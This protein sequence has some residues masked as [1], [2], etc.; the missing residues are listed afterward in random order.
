MKSKGILYSF[1]W[2]V[3]RILKLSVHSCFVRFLFNCHVFFL[4][5]VLDKEKRNRKKCFLILTHLNQ[6]GLLQTLAVMS[7]ST[8]SKN[9]ACFFSVP[10]TPL[11]FVF[12]LLM[13]PPTNHSSSGIRV[14]TLLPNENNF[15]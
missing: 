14:R 9:P 11:T 8:I 5:S 2:S 13:Q 6:T 4:M 3:Y 10:K 12:T 7:K 1:F 15:V